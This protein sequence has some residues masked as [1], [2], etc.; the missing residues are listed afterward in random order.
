MQ[1]AYKAGPGYDDNA[2]WIANRDASGNL[3]Y[4]YDGYI[5]NH[6]DSDAT[7]GFMSCI[8][9]EG[10]IWFEN[11]AG[12]LELVQK[13][14]F[15]SST[16]ATVA[17]YRE[18]T[19][20]PGANRIRICVI[21]KNGASAGNTVT[22]DGT[23]VKCWNKNYPICYDPLLANTLRDG[24]WSTTCYEPFVNL[25]DKDGKGALFTTVPEAEADL[26]AAY[27]TAD[28]RAAL[29]AML[30][31]FAKATFGAGTT[32]DLNG[33]PTDVPFA[34]DALEGA[35]HIVGGNLTVKDWT[36][37][38]T[39]INAETASSV[40]T[41]RITFAD[42]AKLLI[43]DKGL[44]ANDAGYPILEAAGGIGGL[45]ELVFLDRPRRAAN[46]RLILSEDGQTLR[47]AG[48]TTGLC[49]IFR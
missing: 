35:P 42:G 48:G 4:Q 2:A 11:A 13:G 15:F 36:L 17:A 10:Q 27:G 25:L 26:F 29:R 18:V 34:L 21:G 12:E 6:A 31:S 37:T 41:G 20:K 33:L 28:E 23:Q 49:V 39:A 7:W 47:L 3:V 5:W 8:N 24:T 16:T 14:G 22:V 46:W 45:P 44:K 38:A 19:L 43:H 9:S 1:K 32:L 30:P 40:S